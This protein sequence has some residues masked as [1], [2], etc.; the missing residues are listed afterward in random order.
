MKNLLI[1]T[2]LVFSVLTLNA[3]ETKKTRKQKKAEKEAKL[4]EQTKK[5]IEANAWEFDAT[6]MLPAQGRSKSL[7]TDYN[8]ILKDNNV[9]SYL[10]YFGRAYSASYGSSESPMIFEAPIEDY[11]VK[12]GK[13]GSYI[14]KF[15]AMNKGDKVEFT[16]NVSVT[17]FTSL[18][19]ISTNRQH[20]SYHGE[21][22]EIE[23][24]EK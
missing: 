10:P 5:L 24:E 21:L 4:I 13:K 2:V 8:V 17:G 12:D 11:S 6:Q 22:V 23:E 1:I 20:I 14:V 7:T 9:N 19:I 3:Q 15:S 18:N 16:F